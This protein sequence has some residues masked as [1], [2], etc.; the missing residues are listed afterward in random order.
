MK[1]GGTRR[2]KGG[3]GPKSKIIKSKIFSRMVRSVFPKRD[4]TIHLGEEL[5]R[6]PSMEKAS[7]TKK[8]K[9]MKRNPMSNKSIVAPEDI[10]FDKI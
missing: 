2:R 3:L 4:A 9:T 6:T 5:G 7:L 1:K 8:S 10:H